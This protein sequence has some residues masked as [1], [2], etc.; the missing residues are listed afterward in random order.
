MTEDKLAQEDFEAIAVLNRA[1]RD[2]AP[3][4]PQ[5]MVVFGD[6]I[7]SY[8][9]WELAKAIVESSDPKL[10][11]AEAVAHIMSSKRS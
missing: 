6:I 7:I 2:A 4:I 8:E 3:T 9:T 1:E 5:G 10:T 11:L